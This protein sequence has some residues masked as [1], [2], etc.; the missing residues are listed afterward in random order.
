[1]HDDWILRQVE[2]MAKAGARLFGAEAEQVEV[3][4]PEDRARAL[5]DKFGVE[6]LCN[7]EPDTVCEVVGG[8]EQEPA[9]WSPSPMC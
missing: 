7:L 1:M 6:F 5:V 8:R 3:H 4:G 2:A 9:L